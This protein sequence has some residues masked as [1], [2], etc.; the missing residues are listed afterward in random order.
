M[1]NNSKPSIQPE[2]QPRRNRLEAIEPIVDEQIA[3]HRDMRRRTFLKAAAG[4]VLGEGFLAA[5]AAPARPRV[6]TKQV[7]ATAAS[8][9]AATE[10][11]AATATPTEAETK[12]PQ[13]I[14]ISG[15]VDTDP[16][17]RLDETVKLYFPP[18][19]VA[20]EQSLIPE[21]DRLVLN[22]DLKSSTTIKDLNISLTDL[23]DI[24]TAKYTTGM[25]PSDDVK[26]LD[27][28]GGISALVK[29]VHKDDPSFEISESGQ[30][31]LDEVEVK[32]MYNKEGGLTMAIMLPNKQFTYK[33]K[34]GTHLINPFERFI[35]GDVGFGIRRRGDDPSQALVGD[36][37]LQAKNI[38]MWNGKGSVV[39]TANDFDINTPLHYVVNS[40]DSTSQAGSTTGNETVAPQE[41]GQK[42][43]IW[44]DET[45]WAED[46]EEP[47]QKWWD[48][49]GKNFI[50]FDSFAA[51]RKEVA[52]FLDM[53]R[54]THIVARRKQNYY[55][56][57][58]ISKGNC[59]AILDDIRGLAANS[60]GHVT[61]DDRVY[62]FVPGDDCTIWSNDKAQK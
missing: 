51:G 59:R 19:V 13:D 16:K 46:H 10:P 14:L 4:F 58:Y 29:N 17:N 11:P 50:K 48:E 44:E 24:K 3:S 7:V 6:V 41:N 43:S 18:K 42:K 28:A 38:L 45:Q 39:A 56:K 27:I 25:T 40:G 57:G 12:K 5:C 22:F 54:T 33:D 47:T 55:Q 62:D 9:P 34:F 53:I 20:G 35:K 8:A 32:S 23:L 36:I 21:G 2:S 1:E 52:D 30:Q 31:V 37:P 15:F 26:G 60:F 49:V 61:F